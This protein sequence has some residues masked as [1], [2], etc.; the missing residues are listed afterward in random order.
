MLEHPIAKA[1]YDKSKRNWKIFWRRADLKWH[2]Y[3]PN[4]EVASIEE[5]LAI[6]EKDEHGYFFG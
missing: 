4:S 3:T 5:F 6:V 1:T 2:G